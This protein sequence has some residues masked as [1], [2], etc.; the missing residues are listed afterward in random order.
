MEVTENERLWCHP[1]MEGWQLL[2]EHPSF[3]ALW[4]DRPEARSAQ[5]LRGSPVRQPQ[6]TTVKTCSARTPLTG[7]PPVP[8][9]LPLSLLDHLTAKLL[10]PQSLSQ[11]L[12]LRE[13]IY[14]SSAFSY[15]QEFY[16]SVYTSAL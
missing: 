12:L 4:W 9:S 7:F 5:F 14:L 3:P 11:D 13:N 10:G 2:D 6:T 15:S 16:V 1:P 8:V